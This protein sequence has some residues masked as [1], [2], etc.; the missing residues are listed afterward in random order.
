MQ[1]RIGRYELLGEL[2]RGGMA[3]VFR[4]RDPNF[5][6]EVA[7]KILPR[8]LLHDPTFKARFLRE[9]QT[10]ATLEHPAIVPVYDFGE[11]DGQPY[12][13]M[14]LMPGG[15]L[16]DRLRRGPV[17]FSETLR[18]VGQ[19]APALDR[20]HLAGIVHRDLKPANILFDREENAYIADFGLAKIAHADVDLSATAVYGTPAYM[21]PE[22]AKGLREIDGRADLYALGVIAYH[23]LAGRAP[24]QAD[25]PVAL[26]LKHVMEPAPRL[27]EA[28][29]DLPEQ[30]DQVLQRAMAKDPRD[31]FAT[32]S[33]LHAALAASVATEPAEPR[34]PEPGAPG[35]PDPLAPTRPEPP[36][37]PDAPT[38]ATPG[39]PA[40]PAGGSS[41]ALLI[42]CMALAGVG[43]L[44]A[45]ALALGGGLLF[46]RGLASAPTATQRT[47]TAT[48]TARPPTATT[49][50]GPTR[51]PRPQAT[52]A[53]TEL[54]GAAGL[55]DLLLTG[56]VLF[57]PGPA[58][59]RVLYV[60]SYAMSSSQAVI[61][62]VDPQAGVAN[63]LVPLS[64]TDARPELAFAG[65]ALAILNE[66]VVQVVDRATGQDR[67]RATLSDVAPF[68][69]RSA[70]LAIVDDVVVAETAD[71]IV[72]G[73]DLQSGDSLWRVELNTDP[74]GFDVIDGQIVLIDEDADGDGALIIVDPSDGA[75]GISAPKCQAGGL[76]DTMTSNATFVPA[77]AERRML[78]VFGFFGTCLAQIDLDDPAASGDGIAVAG[79]GG[80][81]VLPVVANTAGAYITLDGAIYAVEPGARAGRVLIESDDLA[82]RAVAALETGV[83][84]LQTE[85]RGTPSSALVLLDP[86]TGTPHWSVEL[87]AGQPYPLGGGTILDDDATYLT[88][89]I[90]PAEQVMVFRQLTA[91]EMGGQLELDVLGVDL[92]NGETRP[93][94][95]YRLVQESAIASPPELLVFFPGG[96]WVGIDG[97]LFRLEWDGNRMTT[98]FE[99]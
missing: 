89:E 2:G 1:T 95:N 62:A 55:E 16:A 25:T 8:E 85:S 45:A 3:A 91:T 23:M 65:D 97:G 53:P 64:K 74:I 47:A 70:C 42:G 72:H 34:R 19:L 26:A 69:R 41:P 30:A 87:G 35:W 44:G 96:A 76:P 7:V 88:V 59:P 46:T 9:A 73:L 13:V 5:N 40:Q 61:A 37:G 54:T 68:C 29:P 36:S 58:D 60:V 50:P 38:R 21:S 83:L 63:W 39:Q 80:L 66:D 92:S 27:R 71:G 11:Q 6:R 49:R 24:Y 52:A 14:R 12:L 81:D 93:L 4:A 57:A 15:S 99:P 77:P 79:T 43:L 51:T 31:R 56:E 86:A 10:I 18:I 20:A 67:W 82:Y 28:R 84:V 32:A 90:G 94:A 22:Q 78:A 33:H 17:S 98:V 75:T 48:I